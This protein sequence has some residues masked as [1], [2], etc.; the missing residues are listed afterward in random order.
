VYPKAAR[1]A[2]FFAIN[3]MLIVKKI[4]YDKMTGEAAAE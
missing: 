3:N 4:Y 1:N 2:M